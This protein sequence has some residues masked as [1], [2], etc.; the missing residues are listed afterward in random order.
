MRYF[1]IFLIFL[2]ACVQQKESKEHTHTRKLVRPLAVAF[3]AKDEVFVKVSDSKLNSLIL[4]VFHQLGDKKVLIHQSNLEAK[5]SLIRI[6]ID[7]SLEEAGG[8]LAAV[9]KGLDS[10]NK[11]ISTVTSYAIG[12]QDEIN[13]IKQNLLKN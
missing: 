5:D 4:E 13:A 9:V 6:N 10:N 7:S 2:S 8:V 12:E 11:K 1:A 3:L